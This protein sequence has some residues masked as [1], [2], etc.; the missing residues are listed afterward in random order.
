[1]LRSSVREFS[2]KVLSPVAKKIDLDNYINKDIL[3]QVSSMGYFALRVPDKYGGPNLSTM[4]SV[5]V[6]EELARV[7]GAISIMA[8]VSGTM[9]A[10]PLVHYA[11]DE[12]KEEYLTKLGKGKIG[13]FA[14][15]EPC[16]GSDAANI[17]TRA[18]IDGND[19][20]INGRKTWITNSTYADFFLVAARTGKQE[21]RHKGISIFVLDK[22]N[23]IEISK[24][25]M[26]GVRGSGTSELLFKD[27]RV[28][29]ENLVGELNNG[30][31]IVMDGV[32]EGRVVTAAMGLGIMQAAFDESLSYAKIRETM[33]KPIIEHEMVQSMI[34]E[35][36]TKLE[37]SRLLI[38][39]AAQK[40]D[41]NDIDYP[42]WSSIA[43]YA[44]AKWGVDLVR[45]AMQ[46][47][48][49]FGYSKE[50]NIERYYRDIKG[51]EIG[52][53]TNEIQKLVI[54]K[55]LLGKIAAV[56]K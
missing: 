15:S 32:N 43:K 26:M 31:K 10:Y 36:K 42:M 1:L 40:I 20:I 54:A 17:I 25:D 50:S 3:D 11:S 5:V 7:S 30:F 24:L 34:A 39:N 44:T 48:G 27:C 9:V 45:L 52:D 29:K 16:C 38:Y 53:G 28:P 55:S 18:E 56:K 4:E 8:T 51:I 12:I 33:G 23:C 49:G 22:N 19:F 37:A 35:M 21:E 47:E 14:L 46:V 2:E 41:N 6:V 13:A